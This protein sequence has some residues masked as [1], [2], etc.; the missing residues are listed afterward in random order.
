M[1]K[2][3]CR[4]HPHD[5]RRG[6]TTKRW[7]TKKG[8]RRGG[9]AFTRNALYKLLTNVTYIGKIKYKDETHVGEHTAIVPVEVFN[10][11]QTNLKCNGQ[12]GGT[13][14]RNKHSALLKGLL[15]C[16]SCGC[17]MTHSFSCK[18]NKRYRYYVCGKA[19]QRGWSECPSPSVPAGEI[20]RFVVEQIRTI[21]KDSALL[22]QTTI[23]VQQRNQ[24]ECKRLRD[25]QKSL[26][27]QM[28]D[29]HA[30]LQAII[31]NPNIASN[32]SGL[33]EIQSRL[34]T[35]DRRSRQIT[36]DLAAIEAQRID[37]E[38]IKE[39]L[40][41]FDNLWQSLP[42]KEQVR[43]VRLLIE[44]VSFDGPGGNVSIT[45]HPTGLKSLTQNQ[46]EHAQ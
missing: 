25:E 46:L 30:K 24:L 40:T 35:A 44:S 4:S 20:E 43:V 42:P 17:I 38:Q 2:M 13:L 21:G 37:D 1:D 10:R 28:R 11:V 34:E 19:M 41:G 29:D 12:S 26:A 32:L 5:N 45:F 15:H 39:V 31:A 6:W 3:P 8:D 22:K 27:R 9:R 18:G 33:S 14:V 36:S 16:K 23:D 7:V